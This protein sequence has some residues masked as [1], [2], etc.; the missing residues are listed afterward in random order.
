MRERA[1]R[2]VK[3][4][5]QNQKKSIARFD[6]IQMSSDATNAM[7]ADQHAR[8]ADT[9]V[10][11]EVILTMM[12]ESEVPLKN[13]VYGV[14]PMRDIITEVKHDN[15]ERLVDLKLQ[16]FKL[17]RKEL[18]VLRLMATGDMDKV[19]AVKQG[20]TVATIKVQ[21]KTICTKMKAQGRQKASLKAIIHGLVPMPTLED[22]A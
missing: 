5:I 17:S 14:S 7:L 13:D 16:E 15:G 1:L 4:T 3:Q 6:R 22:L 10:I 18:Q 8:A 19:I 11:W 9:L 2:F 20:V 21:V 12:E